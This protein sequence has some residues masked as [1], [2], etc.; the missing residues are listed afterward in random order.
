AALASALL[1]AR[2]AFAPA[3]GAATRSLTLAARAA[4]TASRGLAASWLRLPLR[5]ST[6]CGLFFRCFARRWRSTACATSATPAS[7]CRGLAAAHATY[8]G[9]LAHGAAYRAGRLASFLFLFFFLVV[10][11]ARFADAGRI[12]EVIHFI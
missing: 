8:S 5:L 7:G 6:A 3:A 11:L 9:T 1:L 10:F 12:A 4:A 2:R